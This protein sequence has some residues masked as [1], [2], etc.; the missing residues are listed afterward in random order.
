MN[1]PLP[2]PSRLLKWMAIFARW[3]LG[4]LLAMWLLLAVVWGGLHGWIVPRISEYRPQLETLAAR[5]LGVPVRIGALSAR[6]EGLVPSFEIE[7]VALLDPQGR[8]AL[9][10]PRV[11]VSLSPRSAMRW[12][13][14][15]LYIENPRLDVRREADGRLFVAGL[16]FNPGTADDGAAADWIFT[17]GEVVIR[18]GMLRW[19]DA[20]RGAPPLALRQVDLL[21]RNQGWRHDMRLDA[22]PPRDWGDRF[23]LRAQFRQPFL[24]AHAGAWQ[25]W[26][27]H[28][29]GE[30]T[31]VDVAQLRHHV[32][33]DDIE[34]NQGRG[35]LRLWADV[36]RGQIGEVTA[37]LALA[38]VRATLGAGLE[39]LALRSVEGRFRGSRWPGGMQFSTQ[40]LQFSAQ[41]GLQWP[42]GDLSFRWVPTD[43]PHPAQGELRADRLELAVLAQIVS[44][45][46][47][48]AEI[49]EALRTYAPRGLVQDLQAQ[50]R[51]PVDHPQTYQVKGR[52]T[53]L[54]LAAP[55]GK[56]SVPPQTFGVWGASADFDLNQNGGR[57]QLSIAQ[58]G[59]VLPG[60][61][62]EPVLPLH[63]LTSTLRWQLQGEQIALQ[64]QDLR[65]ANADA[66]GD[67]RLSW[68]TSDP[69][70]SSSGARFPGVLDLSGS[71]QRADGTRV[72]RYL[73]LAID[74]DVRHYV[75]DAV[76]AG[77][78]TQAQFKVRGDLHDLPFERPGQGEFHISA[79]IQDATYAYVP[80]RLQPSGEAPWPVLT[81]L[82]GDLIFDRASMF[83][84]KARANFV[85]NAK[86]QMSEVEASI[87]DL[88]HSVVAVQAKGRGPLSEMLALVAGSPLAGLTE[89]ALDK[90][91]ATG[92]ADLQLSLGLPIADIERATVQGSVGFA[93]NDVQFTPDVPLLSRVRGAVQFSETGF[94]LAGLQAQALG[95]EVRLEGGM[96]VTAGQAAEASVQVRAQGTATA[97]GLRQAH[98]LGLLTRIAEHAR[99]STPYS[100]TVGVRRG[101]PE[102]QVSSTLQGMAVDLPAPLRKTEESRLPLQYEQRLTNESA[103]A[104]P[105]GLL[106]DRISLELGGIGSVVYV[107]D[108]GAETPRVLRGA[109]GVGLNPGEAAP[110]PEAGVQANLR[111]KQVDV[112][113][114][115][116]AL[117][118]VA[119]TGQ[120]GAPAAAEGGME[121][122]L[123]THVALQ[124][125]TLSAHGRT[126][127]DV[128]VGGSREGS[129]WRANLDA[130]ELDGYVEFRLPAAA[131]H[132][133]RLF[134]RL[135]RLTLPQ[136]SAQEVDSLL[137]DEPGSL[138][139]LDIVV[140]D[141]ELNG[142]KLG[143]LEVEAQNRGGLDH[144]QRE[145]RLGKFNLTTA[146]ASLTGSGNWALL[147]RAAGG[148]APERRTVMNFRLDIRDSGELLARF[149]MPD[150]VRRGKGR[151][152][153]QVAWVGAP[154]NPDY[155]SMTG[156]I[157]VNMEAGQFLKADPGLAKLLGV[158]SLQSLPRRLT[159]DFRDVFSEGF[160]FD[161]VRG[162]MR[163]EHGIARTNNLQMK[164]VQ[165]A[166]LMEGSADL[167][168]ET[169]DLHVVVVPEINAMTASLVA[170]AINPVIGLGSF[171]A[172]VVLRGPLS[173]AATQ[174]FRI[175]GTWADPR[176][177]RMER[178]W[179]APPSG[180]KE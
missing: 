151:L 19:T 16:P 134:A 30:F 170:T 75:R 152:E 97:E 64:A 67:A 61:F 161:F 80:R 68:R 99:G 36:Q 165:A 74:A 58:G 20:L 7:D 66:Q 168:H 141:F 78:A 155:R 124:A 103:A 90:A 94:S 31:R 158:L 55:E 111:M 126:L 33:L 22:T 98:P 179:L 127:H 10:L 11:V 50:W 147:T 135:A 84:R 18:N 173:A 163:I 169:Q 174:E 14:E 154:I 110:M 87:P 113:A 37:D 15:Q 129:T 172:Q 117:Q 46:P 2:N 23:T 65:F 32:N 171:L 69:T 45:L 86:L 81:R 41:S 177:V 101:I 143:R 54:A 77:V 47:L 4:L 51:G 76:T 13:F 62:E 114:W 133:G 136:G 132:G 157:N 53:G 85:G 6:T 79:K 73:P 105:S 125:E 145:W 115:T 40:A 118:G 5:A 140:D 128:V 17:Q 180:G 156:Q 72:H 39:P 60:I 3:S 123:P 150:V 166:V 8:E 175:E 93:N 108:I 83:V 148:G 120:P 38:D 137:R 34:V 82:S 167:E 112:D 48:D 42:G 138:P 25:R 122:F 44:R 119:K 52:A 121:E 1:E 91:R 144:A 178:R 92:A 63:K 106:H 109:I 35:A 153:G 164:G 102:V 131:E 70:R 59:L 146:E 28:A 56:A 26:S 139:A 12:G 57:A 142:R 104:G 149:G 27:G 159:L 162:D 24:T 107:R 89:H 9:R 43:G 71:L 100:V 95:G 96:K 160:A 116:A 29:Y 21:I 49:H 130:R 88:S 176:I